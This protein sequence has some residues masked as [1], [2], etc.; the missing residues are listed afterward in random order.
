LKLTRD[1]ISFKILFLLYEYSL[2]ILIISSKLSF[3][4]VLFLF[5]YPHLIHRWI[6]IYSPSLA[7]T[8]TGFI[9]PRQSDSRS[10]GWRS[11]CLLQRQFGQWLVKPLPFTFA[12]Q[13]P[14]TKSSI[15]RV[16]F[17]VILINSYSKS[18]F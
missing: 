16:N 14:Q 15:F 5:S 1:L 9:S 13:F 10:P 11:T 17:K 4:E 6:I 8:L 12:P 18:A 7:S 2:I 3:F